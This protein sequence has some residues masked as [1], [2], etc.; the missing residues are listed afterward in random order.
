MT[1]PRKASD[2]LTFK[3]VRG[4]PLA[5]LCHQAAA[6]RD[7]HWGR[8]ITYSRKV[9]VPLT[10]LCRDDCGYCVFVK[11]P[12]EPGARIMTPDQ[13]MA[14]V[15][16]GAALGCKEVLF[17]LGEKPERR[18]QMARHALAAL[19]HEHMTDYLRSLCERV[20]A[21]TGL[22]PHVN[23][24]TLDDD[25]IVM[26]KSVSGSM[27]MMLESVSKRLCE[28]G[29]PHHGCPDKVPVQRLRTLERAGR[30]GVPFTTGILIGIGET[31][32]ERLD[33]LAAINEIHARHGH[34][35]EVIVQNF[36]AKPGIAMADHPEPDH[37]DMRRTLAVARLMLAP[38]ISLQAPPNLSPDYLDYIDCGLNDWGGVSP[39]T[40]DHINPERAWPHI[41]SLAAGT[42]TKGYR[43]QERLT[44]YPR[45][46][47][48]A[49]RYLDP[50]VA[51]QV[52]TM[53][54]HDGLALRQTP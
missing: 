13:V 17:S 2:F 45:Y 28:P 5:A 37:D 32:A 31:W 33:T 18:Y 16:G 54:R 35:Q 51:K 14:V 41:E 21:E 44:V 42:A 40:I 47:A 8:T 30:H 48:K 49:A 23:A 43:L 11:R 1:V 29:G 26:L 50:A 46:I 15:E 25:E 53:A 24:G 52:G 19:G 39:L 20:L 27:G 4:D 12:G 34:I 36:R 10:T 38:A 22:L 3:H 9:F 7:T 6:L